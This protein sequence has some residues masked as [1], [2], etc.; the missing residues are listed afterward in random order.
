MRI[1]VGQV[2]LPRG[3]ENIISF[4]VLV[5]KERPR[6]QST[7]N[8][9]ILRWVEDGDWAEDVHSACVEGLNAAEQGEGPQRKS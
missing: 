8:S 5:Q 7:R 2:I 4:A 1:V 9:V 3:E 6:I